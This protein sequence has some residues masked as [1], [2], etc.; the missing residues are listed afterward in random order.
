MRPT[1]ILCSNICGKV[2]TRENPGRMW[3]IHFISLFL[4]PPSLSLS[5]P[6]PP[7]RAVG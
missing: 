5:L 1:N 2:I 6:L 4:H 7:Y 3:G